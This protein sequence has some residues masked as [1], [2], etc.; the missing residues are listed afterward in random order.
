MGRTSSVAQSLVPED[1]PCPES[2]VPGYLRPT[3]CSLSR[4]TAGP[5]GTRR[6]RG[7]LGSFRSPV[8]HSSKDALP[9]AAVSSTDTSKGSTKGCQGAAIKRVRSLFMQLP[10]SALFAID[11]HV[12]CIVNTS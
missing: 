4:A 11:M 3:R 9:S 7:S 10:S 12:Y 8:A 5:M 6:I 2:P 1:V